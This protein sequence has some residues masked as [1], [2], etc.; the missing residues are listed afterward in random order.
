M[1]VMAMVAGPSDKSNNQSV[2]SLLTKQTVT[3][4]LSSL[5]LRNLGN[6]LSKGKGLGVRN[7]GKSHFLLSR[8]IEVK[9]LTVPTFMLDIRP[10]RAF[11]LGVLKGHKNH[12]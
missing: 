8:L 6:F 4:S 1:A 9:T 7:D 12:T 2:H 3:V 10:I 11:G 5:Q